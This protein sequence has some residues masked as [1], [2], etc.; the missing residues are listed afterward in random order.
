MMNLNVRPH[1]QL[2]SLAV[3][4]LKITKG[5]AVVLSSTAGQT[6]QP[7]SC[8]FSTSMSMLNMLV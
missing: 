5:N 1:F 7:G 4:F 3:P 8:I 6:P 2:I